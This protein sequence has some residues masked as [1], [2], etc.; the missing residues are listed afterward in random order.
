M[1]FKAKSALV[2]L[3]SLVLS[4]GCG[5]SSGG[6]TTNNLT[7]S[8]SD[9]V[10]GGIY[11]LSGP[12]AFIGKSFS[13]GANSAV[14]AI[15]QAG[16]IEGRKVVL[17]EEDTGGDAVDAVTAFRKLAIEHPAF[18]I[19]PSSVDF[20]GIVK[21]FDASKI[22]DFLIG[23][24]TALDDNPYKYVFR[25]APSDSAIT[26]VMAIY[27]TQKK[28][29]NAVL[30]F[31][32]SA[33]GVAE[34]DS[35]KRWYTKLGGKITADVSIPTG[36][37]SYRS[38]VSKA[39]ATK[40]DAIFFKTDPQT[41]ATIFTNMRELG[42]L[43][44]PIIGDNTTTDPSFVTAIGNPDLASKYLLGIGQPS[45]KS[46][47]FAP[48]LAAYNAVNPTFKLTAPSA[49]NYDAVLSGAL[50]VLAA[51]STDGPAVQSHVL[52][53]TNPP[54]QVCYTFPECR[55]LLKAGKKINFEG[56]AL[57]MDFDAHHNV[58][59]NYDVVQWSGSATT[60]V[61]HVTAADVAAAEK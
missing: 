27:A 8:K 39:F 23:G 54:G 2:L 7:S 51:Q 10:I 41:A 60:S 17:H 52:T 50:A 33:D 56:S 35:T 55:D 13:A 37:S 61:L 16:G 30:M 42:L 24:T 34:H 18:I 45:D 6:S 1:T 38:E 20:S 19:G 25:A 44:V 26:A 58:Y 29:M 12:R 57:N 48:F 46:P 4:A 49:V 40:P 43:S 15:N 53:V 11:P 9:I 59:T 32:T 47:A 28:Y 36:Q 3:A 22:T 14:Y 5:T 21:S 31:D